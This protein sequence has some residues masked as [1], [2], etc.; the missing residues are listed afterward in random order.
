MWYG[1][2][3]RNTQH[4][5]PSSQ[6]G[7][8]Q[9]VRDKTDFLLR[10]SAP[11]SPN[12]FISSLL[13]PQVAVSHPCANL[14][15]KSATNSISTS[16]KKRYKQPLLMFELSVWVHPCYNNILS[17]ICKTTIHYW[18]KK[19]IRT[20]S[21]NGCHWQYH[22]SPTDSV[23]C[24]MATKCH[25]SHY[26]S[27]VQQS[28]FLTSNDYHKLSFKCAG[29]PNEQF[30]TMDGRFHMASYGN[31]SS[32]VCLGSGKTII[33]YNGITPRVGPLLM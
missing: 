1:W 18:S 8:Q 6:V 22:C 14:L 9:H 13:S 15:S 29:L 32:T 26:I 12:F 19:C 21:R 10:D 25:S 23:S 2:R 30:C 33:F 27:Q 5:S 28:Q 4:S 20:R 11:S 16:R 3:I 7:C 17:S 24:I 31:K